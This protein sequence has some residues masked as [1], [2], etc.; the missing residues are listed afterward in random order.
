MKVIYLLPAGLAVSSLAVG[1]LK[2]SPELIIL[3]KIGLC[4]YLVKQLKYLVVGSV[5]VSYAIGRNLRM[6]GLTGGIG[7]GK[8]SVI[9]LVRE[10]APSVKII[11]CDQIAK[12]LVKPGTSAHRRIH[13]AFGDYVLTATGEIDR[14]SLADLIFHNAAKRSQLNRILHPLVFWTILKQLAYFRLTGHSKVLLDCPLLYE[15]GLLVHFCAPVIVVHIS[16]EAVWLDRVSKRD[17]I[18]LFEA[19]VKIETQIPVKY[20]VQRADIVLDNV[21]SHGALRAEVHELVKEI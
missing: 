8:S 19:K 1:L 7:C 14:N 13:R 3:A 17:L 21:G 9:E 20:K 5:V 11:D 15:S 10:L 4:L 16:D 6:I 18:S 12:E 2:R